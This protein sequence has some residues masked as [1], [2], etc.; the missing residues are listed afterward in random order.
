M[1]SSCPVNG[2]R[3]A[4]SPK[5]E[6]EMSRDNFDEDYQQPNLEYLFDM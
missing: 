1:F 6:Y 3:K 5:A 4:Y 2:C